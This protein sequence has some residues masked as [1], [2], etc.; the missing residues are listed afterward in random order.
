[1][2]RLPRLIFIVRDTH[3]YFFINSRNELSADVYR[4]ELDPLPGIY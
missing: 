1:M 2:Y 4:T 3:D